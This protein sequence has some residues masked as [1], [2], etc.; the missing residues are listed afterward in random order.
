[1]RLR[2]LWR[3]AAILATALLFYYG[4][5]IYPLLR[6]IDWLV[7]DWQPGTPTL[8]V[9]LVL[10]LALR[11]MA[12][13]FPHPVTRWLGAMSL[14]WMGLCFQLFALVVALEVVGVV[15]GVEDRVLGL[16]GLAGIA[17]LGTWAF[18]NAQVLKVRRIPVESGGLEGRRLVQL[19]DVHI[20]SRRPGFL[21]RIVRRVNALDGDA[22]LITG[23]LVDANYVDREDLRHLGDLRAPTY[24]T[25]GNHERYEDTDRILDDLTALGVRVLRNEA[26]DADPFQFIGIDDADARDT[27][28]RGLAGLS[29]LPARYRV[30]L[31]HR[32][33]GVEDAAAWGAQLMLSGHTHRGQI[34]PFEYIVKRVH[35]RLSGSHHVDGL[36]LYVSPGTGTWG[37]VLRTNGR[38]EVTLFEFGAC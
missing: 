35:R 27:V 20:G 32:P 34:F 26:V 12:S 24:F 38:C 30:L 8:L 22:V 37:P 11:I 29:P 3:R 10:P 9:L 15:S 2:A 7:P 36:H 5:L 13:T 17:V 1:M 18:I 21:R 31:F 33:E 19:S 28:A 16:A 25:L 23:D 14:T 6:L 4:F